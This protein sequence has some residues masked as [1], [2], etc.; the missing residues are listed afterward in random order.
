MP[1]QLISVLRTSS[2]TFSHE[3]SWNVESS[4]ALSVK[5]NY[6]T[7]QIHLWV[8]PALF[9][10]VRCPPITTLKN[11]LLSPPACG[12]RAVSPGSTC[13]L[14]C[15]QGYTLQGNRKAVCLG[16]GN[17]TANVYKAI[18][19]GNSVCV[20][21]PKEEIHLFT[22]AVLRS[23]VRGRCESCKLGVGL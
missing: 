14:T 4:S 22:P 15:R 2:T 19:T 7:Y 10:E 3:M 23:E 9:P 12:K 1:I 18:C 16:S 8:S 21:L 5:I 20:C 13:L 6:N 11:I 17:W